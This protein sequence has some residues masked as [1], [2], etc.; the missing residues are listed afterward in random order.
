[1]ISHVK[2]INFRTL[3]NIEVDHLKRISL[4]SGR[5]NVGKSTFLESI[6]LMMDHSSPDSFQAL[7]SFRGMVGSGTSFLW[8]PLFY[9]FDSANQVEIETKDGKQTSHLAYKRD[10]NYSL[11]KV[12]GL[13]EET[14]AQF[15][16]ASRQSYSL[17]FEFEDGNY[18]ENG[19]FSI[20][21]AN[22]LREVQTSLP[23]NEIQL[24]PPTRYITPFISRFSSS[25]LN[26]IG[27]LELQGKKDEVI[28]ILKLMDESIEDVVTLSVQ[29]VTQ[30]YIRSNG[31]LFPLQYAGDGIIVLLNICLAII[32]NPNGIVL[33]DEIESGLHYSMY[34]KLWH[35]IDELSREYNCQVIAT[36]H[37]YEMIAA[38]QDHLSDKDDFV[39]YRFG[40]SNSDIK[41]F[42]FDYKYLITALDSDLEIR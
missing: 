31:R 23:G 14:V 3:R 38:V 21:G 8:E 1:M 28:S 41:S 13:S 40:R 27:K 30:L 2:I 17:A 11:G 9:N 26:D 36:T 19:H 15:R 34:G 33:I 35:A 18:H 4:I 37:S 29:G 7:N 39:Y 42:E 32:E 24:M 16:A 20:N 10:E 12:K 25:A 5:N 6:F 22:T